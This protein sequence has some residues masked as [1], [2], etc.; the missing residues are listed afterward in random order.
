LFTTCKK[1]LSRF[2]FYNEMKRIEGNQRWLES[3]T[4]ESEATLVGGYA[5]TK[6]VAEKL[7][8]LDETRLNF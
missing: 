2:A 5:Q 3:G 4:L 6:W 1:I 8:R 7:V